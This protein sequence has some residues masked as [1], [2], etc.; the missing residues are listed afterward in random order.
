MKKKLI[1]KVALVTG[2]SRG[3]GAAIANRLADDGA[4]V[5]FSYAASPDR[6]QQIAREI[7]SKGV[8][9]FAVQAD[10]ADPKQVADLVTSVH[11]YFGKLDILINNAGVSFIGVVVG[12]PDADIAALDRQ[13][14]INVNGVA[15]AV[16]TAA[17]LLADGGRIISIG[18]IFASRSPV[19]GI[20]DYAASRAAVAAYTRSW[21]RDLGSP[22]ITVN[23]VQPGAINTAMNPETGAF[24]PMRRCLSSWQHS[25]AMGG[26]KRLP[27]WSLSWPA[28]MRVTSPARGST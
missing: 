22:A 13:F 11:Q 28:P 19:S 16:R 5:A 12:D 3:I 25:G 15:T 14:A 2:G 20:G 7:E 24:A 9:A 23:V 18:T 17:P 10:Q 1:G 26:W 8:R 21:A 6:A 27:P 4:D